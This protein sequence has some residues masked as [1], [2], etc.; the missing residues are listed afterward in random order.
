MKFMLIFSWKSAIEA[1]DHAIARFKTTGGQPPEG[2]TLLGRWTRAD[3]N[4]GF[5]LLETDDPAALGDFSMMWS[6]I[7][8]LTIVPVLNDSELAGVFERAGKNE[9]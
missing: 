8:E 6:D 3:F 5:A 2:V 9:L 1:R 4:G 7:M